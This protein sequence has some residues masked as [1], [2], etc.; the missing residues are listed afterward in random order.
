MRHNIITIDRSLGIF[1]VT[2]LVTW[3]W[4]FWFV[5]EKVEAV[6]QPIDFNHKV[7]TK[8]ANCRECHFVCDDNRDEDGDIDCEECLEAGVPLCAK[9]ALSPKHK[10]P[11][12][13]QVRDCL[14][15][16][17]YDLL[18]L[19]DKPESED[20]PADRKKRVLFEYVGFD[21]D[22]EPVIN[23][24]IPWVR[25]T[26]L[27]RSNV[28]FSHRTHALV[29]KID[30]KICHGNVAELEHALAIPLVE[31]SMTHCLDCHHGEGATDSCL[32]CHR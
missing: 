17:E 31:L 4:A 1:A 22:D 14:R 20:E 26:R 8:R 2:A 24:P 3:V 18:E 21:E 11:G 12:L 13:P 19:R 32:S 15:C 23:K 29:K 5:P 16:H 6:T 25:V 9:H 28:Y 10:L 30:C 27:A 7:H